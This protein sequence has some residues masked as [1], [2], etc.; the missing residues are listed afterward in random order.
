MSI[1]V[2]R[3]QAAILAGLNDFVNDRWRQFG[4]DGALQDR[5]DSYW[6]D[7]EVT[8]IVNKFCRETEFSS[9][10]YPSYGRGITAA[11]KPMSQYQDK[12]NEIKHYNVIEKT[13]SFRAV[14]NVQVDVNAWKA[15]FLSRLTTPNG[16]PGSMTIFGSK[17]T[18]HDML[19]DHLTSE[20][21]T[22]TTSS[23]GRVVKEFKLRPGRANR[24]VVGC[25]AAAMTNIVARMGNQCAR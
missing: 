6:L 19:I 10:V 3:I 24:C 18:N 1:K 7:G 9:L 20:Y 12:P 16:N 25:L 22:V 5:Q 14:H 21:F 17:R 11:Q 23:S 8:N 13:S 4:V 15:I 2:G